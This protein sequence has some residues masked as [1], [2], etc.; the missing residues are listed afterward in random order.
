MIMTKELK[1]VLENHLEGYTMRQLQDMP[2]A[3]SKM[4]F[5]DLVMVNGNPMISYCSEV[6]IARFVSENPDTPVLDLLTDAS[7]RAKY[8]NTTKIGRFLR[9]FYADDMWVTDTMISA[10]LSDFSHR[11]YEFRVVEGSDIAKYYDWGNYA[12]EHGNLWKSCMNDKG[13]ETFEVYADNAQMLCLFEADG[14]KIYGRALLWNEVDYEEQKIKL[15]DRVYSSSPMN[16]ELFKKWAVEH[17]YYYKTANKY[18]CYEFTNG[19]AVVDIKGKAFLHLKKPITEYHDLPYMDTFCGCTKDPYVL[20]ADSWTYAESK[21]ALLIETEDNYVDQCSH[22]GVIQHYEI[23]EELVN[24]EWVQLCEECLSHYVVV[25]TKEHVNEYMTS[26]QAVSL[27]CVKLDE[28]NRVNYA[29]PELVGRLVLD[30]EGGI[31]VGLAYQFKRRGNIYDP[32]T[33]LW[34]NES[35]MKCEICGEYHKEPNVSVAWKENPHEA[36]FHSFGRIKMCKH[37][38]EALAQDG[39]IT[40]LTEEQSNAIDSR[41]WY[42]HGYMFTDTYKFVAQHKHDNAIYQAFKAD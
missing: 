21:F 8:C 2:L 23:A 24:G 22:C 26:E 19:V 41:T 16:D 7:L 29:V 39:T 33:G 34:Y 17:G 15:M 25:A 42:W 9:K 3:E 32:E 5:L 20:A 1:E 27:G 37:C 31:E 12:V 30:H 10:I 35:T 40:K 4:D 38:A 36:S 6:R 18:G 14:D 11:D 28:H 13:A